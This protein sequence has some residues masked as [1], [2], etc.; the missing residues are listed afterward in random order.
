MNILRLIEWEKIGEVPNNAK[1]E[2]CCQEKESCC[3]EE[4]VS[5]EI[6]EDDHKGEE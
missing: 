4:K 2:S 1:E 3:Q 5:E 6:L